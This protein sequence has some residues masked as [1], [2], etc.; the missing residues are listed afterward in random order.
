MKSELIKCSRC[1]RKLLKS[2]GHTI[3]ASCV[4]YIV[5]KHDESIDKFKKAVEETKKYREPIMID[6]NLLKAL[7][8][9]AGALARRNIDPKNAKPAKNIKSLIK[10]IDIDIGLVKG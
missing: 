5:R 4:S 1:K 10:Q 2:N 9:N 8:L 6:R 7:C 3:C